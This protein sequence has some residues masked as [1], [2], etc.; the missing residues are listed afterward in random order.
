MKAN[1]LR[2]FHVNE[3]EEKIS[4]MQEELF[5]LRFQDKIG[6]LSN[7]VRMRIV[8]RDIARAKTVLHEQKSSEKASKE[9]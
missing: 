1:E 9:K 8:K 7:P 4:E 5:N 3:L 6:Q 2:E